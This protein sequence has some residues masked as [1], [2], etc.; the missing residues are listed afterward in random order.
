M[1]WF[2]EQ[3]KKRQEL[4]SKTFEDSFLSLA[5]IHVKDEKNVSDEIL[6]GNY[7][8]TQILTFFRHQMVEIP[9]K[10]TVFQDRVNYA[11]RPY[12]ITHHKIHLDEAW[13]RDNFSPI[14]V[15]SKSKHKPLVL[16]PKGK[17]SYYFISY[18]TGKKVKVT[19][20][21]L[22][23]LEPEAY[24]FYRPLPGGKISLREYAQ[25]IQKSIRPI[26]VILS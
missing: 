26:D 14:L 20:A 1:G 24:S 15:F 23:K 7:A 3:V 25:Y 5:G 16:L 19:K 11:L 9:E 22:D 2:E 17:K 8:I 12:E 6:R 4:D 13:L 18:H 10:I 21:I